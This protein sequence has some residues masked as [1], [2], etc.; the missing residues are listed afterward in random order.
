MHESINQ[1]II[2]PLLAGN[3]LGSP[4]DSFV[5]AEWQD[6][7]GPTEPPRFIAPRHVHHATTKP[8]TCWKAFFACNPAKTKSRPALVPAFSSHA[9]RRTP[10]GMPAPAAFATC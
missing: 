4:N 8:G 2:A 5:I 9:E 6:A 7:G 3:I 10:I 1:P